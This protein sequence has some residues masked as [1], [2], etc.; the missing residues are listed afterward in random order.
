VMSAAFLPGAALVA[1]R[2]SCHG[3]LS[4]PASNASAKG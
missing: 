2:I 4:R 3:V 1:S